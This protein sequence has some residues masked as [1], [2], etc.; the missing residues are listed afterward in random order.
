MQEDEY[1]SGSETD[2]IVKT[3]YIVGHVEIS[4][5]ATYCLTRIA[6]A[7]IGD[8]PFLRVSGRLSEDKAEFCLLEEGEIFAVGGVESHDKDKQEQNIDLVA[9]DV[10]YVHDECGE[11]EEVGQ[12]KSQHGVLV[13]A[14]D[15]FRL[16]G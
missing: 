16:E 10:E 15:A 13:A 5:Q 8:E 12:V 9:P 2:Y 11:E 7:I 4:G 14:G 1:I 3:L 6:Q